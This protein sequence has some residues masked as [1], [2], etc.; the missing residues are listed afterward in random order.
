[1]LT[2]TLGICKRPCILVVAVAVAEVASKAVVAPELALKWGLEKAHAKKKKDQEVMLDEAV[3]V[4]EGE[5]GL[6]QRVTP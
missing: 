2:T 1:M 5:A 3:A 6:T 4:V